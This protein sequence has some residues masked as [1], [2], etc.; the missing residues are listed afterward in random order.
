[1]GQGRAAAGV[2]PLEGE[3]AAALSRCTCGGERECAGC[4]FPGGWDAWGRGEPHPL[5]PGVTP[6]MLA[7]YTPNGEE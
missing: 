7:M 3:T 5:P 4:I 2:V 1:M 6:D